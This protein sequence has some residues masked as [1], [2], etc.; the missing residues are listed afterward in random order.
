MRLPVFLACAPFAALAQT[1]P[2]ELDRIQ[3]TATRV[4]EPAREAPASVGIVERTDGRTDTIGI[5]LSERLTTVP[6]VLARDQ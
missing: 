4:A 3:V 2:V 5:A 1:A 6:G